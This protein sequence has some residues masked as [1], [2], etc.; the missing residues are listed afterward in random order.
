MKRLLCAACG[1][2][3]ALSGCPYYAVPPGTVVMTPASYDRSFSAAAGAL[4]DEGLAITVQDPGSGRVVGT[5][6]TATV[7]ASVRQQVDGSVQ[8]RF[9][10]SD[11]R[12][13]ALLDRISR[14][15]DRRMG[16]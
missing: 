4:R 12:D 2:V 16:R 3:I 5:S 9:D 13:P 7:T 11:S 15:Y 14:S 6:S 1:A 8:V 10:S